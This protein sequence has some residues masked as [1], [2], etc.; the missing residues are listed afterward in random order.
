MT[1]K[2]NWA[3]TGKNLVWLNMV[4]SPSDNLVTQLSSCEY[5]QRKETTQL[6][7]AVHQLRYFYPLGGNF[8][9]LELNFSINSK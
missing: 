8:E 9:K 2:I 5:S 6:I 7:K 1:V 4:I 3:K